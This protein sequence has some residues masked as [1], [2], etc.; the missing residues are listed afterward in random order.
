MREEEKEKESTD[1]LN[2]HKT[3]TKAVLTLCPLPNLEFRTLWT[4][5]GNLGMIP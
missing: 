2:S 4:F 3:F 5:K 1:V